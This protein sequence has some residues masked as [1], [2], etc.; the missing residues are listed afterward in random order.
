MKPKINP[1]FLVKGICIASI[2][3]MFGGRKGIKRR[4]KLKIQALIILSRSKEL[5][6]DLFSIERKTIKN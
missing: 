5:F 6:F 2:G 1:N 3:S 4:P